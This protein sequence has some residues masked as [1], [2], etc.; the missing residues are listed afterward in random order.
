[1][2]F[3]LLWTKVADPSPFVYSFHVIYLGYIKPK[4]RLQWIDFGYKKALNMV[5]W[6]NFL[7]F[8]GFCSQIL[9]LVPKLRTGTA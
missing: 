2:N 5:F 6:S 8:Y 9:I 7:I 4:T 1:M 3:R